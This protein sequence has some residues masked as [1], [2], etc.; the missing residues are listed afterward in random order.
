MTDTTKQAEWPK[1]VTLINESHSDKWMGFGSTNPNL[2]AIPGVFGVE[3]IRA[4][5]AQ[6]QFT[7]KQLQSV[8][9][10]LELG[11]WYAE[12]VPQHLKQIRAAIA[13]LKG[14]K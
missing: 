5:L 11:H 6:P 14:M 1:N 8:L 7:P 13:L 2:C 10:A 9:D 3:Y 4:D 12:G